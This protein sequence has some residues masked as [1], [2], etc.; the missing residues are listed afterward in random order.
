MDTKSD[1]AA[2]EGS[3]LGCTKKRATS[4]RSVWPDV[5]RLVASKT[6]ERRRT[7][8]GDHGLNGGTS[9][10]LHLMHGAVLLP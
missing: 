3:E 4:L 9:G 2:S 5:T 8:K 6:W 1:S 7:P 10:S